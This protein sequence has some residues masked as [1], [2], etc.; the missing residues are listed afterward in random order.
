MATSVTVEQESITSPIKLSFRT[1]Q[2]V[3]IEGTAL[4]EN[5]CGDAMM[6]WHDYFI[7]MCANMRTYALVLWN[8]RENTTF[9]FEVCPSFF[10]IS[11]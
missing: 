7:G 6:R 5:L 4:I 8:L 1:T 10:S 11:R 9:Y 2:R 3:P